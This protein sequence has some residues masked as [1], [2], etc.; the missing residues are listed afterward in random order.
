MPPR[1]APTPLV[2]AADEDD[3][4]RHVR[5]YHRS[6][7]AENRS[8]ATIVAYAKATT[9]LY[10]F[11]RENG[12]PLN[13]EGIRREHIETFIEHLQTEGLGEATISQRYRSLS[14]FFRYLVD[15]DYLTANPMARMRRPRVALRP[16]PVLTNEQVI[17]MLPPERSRT[18]DDIR[19]YAIIVL[20]W[21]SGMRLSELANLRIEDLDL[22]RHRARVRGKGGRYRDAVWTLEA[23]AKLD[24]YLD[25]RARHPHADSPFLWLGKKGHLRA[26]GVAQAMKR[27]ARDAGIDF[28]VHQ[29]RHTFISN[30]LANGGS[31]TDLIELVGWADASAT[32]MLRRYG[33][34]NAAQRAHSHHDQFAPRLR[35]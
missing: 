28:R 25:A 10:A 4:D 2:V 30:W 27:R 21:S 17:A 13:I 6:L 7:R 5:A 31:E 12:M 32:L 14:S 29:L 15:N 9:R 34:A 22:D 8:P 35:R 26:G 18:F 1:T 20:F 3:F 16:P 33:R 19:D 11:L 24:R 23:A